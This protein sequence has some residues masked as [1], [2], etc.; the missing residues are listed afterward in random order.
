MVKLEY[1]NPLH[2]DMLLF[3]A[4]FLPEIVLES[5]EFEPVSFVSSGFSSGCDA[6]LSLA[7][8]VLNNFKLGLLC[9][10]L[11]CT[12]YDWGKDGFFSKNAVDFN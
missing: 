12:K 1:Y 11:H 3:S 9:I 4:Y 8:N 10:C 6:L 5:W 7:E 2:S